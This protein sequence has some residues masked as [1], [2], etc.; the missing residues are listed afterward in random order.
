LWEPSTRALNQSSSPTVFRRIRP[1]AAH[2]R[3][4]AYRAEPTLVTSGTSLRI[5]TLRPGT[6]AGTTASCHRLAGRKPSGTQP[7]HSTRSAEEIRSR[8]PPKQQNGR[9]DTVCDGLRDRHAYHMRSYRK[10][11]I[12][13]PGPSPSVWYLS[14]DTQIDRMF[15]Y[16]ISETS[17]VGSRRSRPPTCGVPLNRTG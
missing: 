4:H 13:R 15:A 3:Q 16:G 12:S 6:V 11:A 5:P 2:P 8:T 17:V 10:Q 1:S 7:F 9:P 14:P